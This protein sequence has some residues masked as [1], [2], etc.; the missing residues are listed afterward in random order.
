MS[1]FSVAPVARK[2]SLL[3]DECLD[4]AFVAWLREQ[5]KQFKVFTLPRGR[6]DEHL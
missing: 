1:S 4:E 5:R 6:S 3:C 2:L